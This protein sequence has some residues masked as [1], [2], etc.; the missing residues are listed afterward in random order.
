MLIQNYNKERLKNLTNKYSKLIKPKKSKKNRNYLTNT[1]AIL[2]KK[3]LEHLNILR[4]AEDPKTA[5]YDLNRANPDKNKFIKINRK[6]V[7]NIY[8][9]IDYD[10]EKFLPDLVALNIP[11]ISNEFPSVSRIYLYQIFIQYKTY[12]K[13]S[14]A[15]NNSIEIMRKG[16]DFETFFSTIPNMK[17]YGREMAL[18]LFKKMN[19]R[20]TGFLEWDEYLKGMLMLRDRKTKIEES[21]VENNGFKWD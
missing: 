13:I 19:E 4:L 1:A 14:I 16:I 10:V 5:Y 20:K 11:R 9:K 8:F 15:V 12:L 18:D 7:E 3:F 2:I 6:H 17:I 21:Y